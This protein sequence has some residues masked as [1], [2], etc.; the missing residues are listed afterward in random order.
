[1]VKRIEHRNGT[2]EHFNENN[3]WHREDGPA[4]IYPDG[5][6]EWWINGKYHRE[7]GPAIVDPNGTKIWCL[8]GQDYSFDKWIEALDK[9]DEEKMELMLYYG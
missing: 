6:K 5:R 1:M 7:D 8:N 2:I 3:H 4:V 9:S